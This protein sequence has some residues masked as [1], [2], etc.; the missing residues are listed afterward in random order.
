MH[1]TIMAHPSMPVAATDATGLNTDDD[2]IAVWLRIS[3]LT[4]SQWPLELFEDCSLHV[5]RSVY[6]LNTGRVTNIQRFCI[7]LPTAC[8]AAD[9]T[10]SRL[11]NGPEFG[12]DWFVWP[13]SALL[14]VDK[15]DDLP[16]VDTD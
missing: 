7:R 10:F 1:I 12:C 11:L 2:R 5:C 16:A 4:D 3:N 15:A 13:I 14:N 8:A 6:V 9:R